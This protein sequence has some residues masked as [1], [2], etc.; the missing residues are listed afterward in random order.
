MTTSEPYTLNNFNCRVSSTLNKDP[1][2]KGSN[3]FD[4]DEETCWNSHQGKPQFIN[5]IFDEPVHISQLQFMFQGGFVGQDGQLWI[6]RPGEE[7]LSKLKEFFPKDENKEQIFDVNANNILRLRIVFPESTDFFG[8]I[9]IYNLEVY[10][11]EL[12]GKQE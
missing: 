2:Y 5:L 3:M 6:Q 12:K 8:R 11:W 9:T 7:K 10:G 4:G 1:E